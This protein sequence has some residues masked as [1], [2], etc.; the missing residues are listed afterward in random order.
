[1]I[2][3]RLARG[4]DARLGAGA[5]VRKGLNKV[6]PDHWS[7]LLGEV[8]MFCFVILVL[9]GTFLAFFFHPSL[10]EVVYEGSYEPMRGQE[11]SEA[12]ASTLHLSF[13]VRFGLLMRQIHH[14]AALVFIAAIVLHLARVFF[15]GAFRKP[16]E[17]NWIIGLT[18]LILAMVN[19]FTG[20]TLPD[21]LLSGTGLRITHSIIL[22][23]PVVGTWLA[24]LIFGGPFP[25]VDI[26]PRLFVIHILVVPVAI[27]A[28]LGL[29]LAILWRQKHAQFPGSGR[30][31]TNVVG[32]KLWP[33][34]TLKMG[35]L[36][37][38]TFAL[39]ALLGGLVQINAIWLYG[40]FHPTA[41]PVPAQPD[42]YFGWIEGAL[43]LSPNWEPTIFGYTVP[44]PFFPAVLVPGITFALLYSWPFLE[45][46]LTGDRDEH[47]L[48]DRPRDHPLRTALGVATISFYTVLFFAGSNDIVA[49]VLDASVFAVTTIYRVLALGLP[50]VTGL[51]TYMLLKRRQRAASEAAAAA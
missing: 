47:H 51:L 48:L 4:I 38:V 14:W 28:L 3:E 26:I 36:F 27:A 44:N 19:G 50:L 29:H 17:L 15:T 20:Y 30:T 45:A 2:L 33:H 41:V 32:S 9:T 43:R 7:F 6:F 1:M 39:L 35:A 49:L 24:F 18:L 12:Y 25:G 21:D 42:W 37:C 23:I 8:A 16:R 34:H 22:S 40:P 11:V 31:E 10:H 46:R 5:F 13:D